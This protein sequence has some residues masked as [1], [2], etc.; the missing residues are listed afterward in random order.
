MPFYYNIQRQ[1]V[2]T[3]YVYTYDMFGKL[4]ARTAVADNEIEVYDVRSR[5]FNGTVTPNYRQFRSLNGYLPTRACTDAIVLE[6]PMTVH[7]VRMGQIQIWNQTGTA[8]IGVRTVPVRERTVSHCLALQTIGSV[9]NSDVNECWSKVRRKVLDQDFNAPIFIAEGRKTVDLIVDRARSLSRAYSAFRKGKPEQV[10]R[11][12]GLNPGKSHRT[13]LEYKYGWM[14]VLMDIHGA[15]KTLATLSPKRD[16]HTFRARVRKTSIVRDTMNQPLRNG[17]RVTEA[18]AWVT[19]RVH[20]PNLT[21]ANRLG[22][23]NPLSVAW[24]LIPFSFV[25]DWF[26]NI[27]DCISELTAWNGVT[28]LTGGSSTCVTFNG[29]LTEFNPSYPQPRQCSVLQRN[30]SRIAGVQTMPRLVVKTKPLDIVKIITAA[31]L[32]RSVVGSKTSR[33]NKDSTLDARRAKGRIPD[34]YWNF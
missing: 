27:G 17:Q 4:T 26:V 30:Y 22:L 9:P 12:L 33:V 34:A 10:R 8:V 2:P 14:P 6:T 32:M 13:W 21:V 11:A 24:E 16:I 5:N 31:A 25:A 20:N 15:A 1:R 23:L 28:I 18:R 29:T 3:A 7:Q 19:V